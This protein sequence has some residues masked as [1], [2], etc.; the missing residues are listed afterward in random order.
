MGSQ[1]KHPLDG[2]GSVC[3]VKPKCL[4]KGLNQ[5]DTIKRQQLD[6]CGRQ[7]LTFT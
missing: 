3:T 7:L 1:M 5:P 4:P 2:T 6:L